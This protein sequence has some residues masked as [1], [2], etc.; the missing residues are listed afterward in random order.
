MCGFFACIVIVSVPVA[1]FIFSR[2][3]CIC[4]IDYTYACGTEDCCTCDGSAFTCEWTCPGPTSNTSVC[5]KDGK[6]SSC[7][8]KRF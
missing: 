3:E 4:P 5:Y 1:V 7:N 6:I 8:L 2:R